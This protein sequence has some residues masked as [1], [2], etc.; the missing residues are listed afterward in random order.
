MQPITNERGQGGVLLCPVCNRPGTWREGARSFTSSFVRVR[1]S[2]LDALVHVCCLNR[3]YRDIE[4]QIAVARRRRL[5]LG[6]FPACWRFL[7]GSAQLLGMI[8]KDGPKDAARKFRQARIVGGIDK[9]KGES[10]QVVRNL[11]GGVSYISG[12]L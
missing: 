1:I 3:L 11:D 7:R 5:L 8:W 6:F 9:A 10:I 12:D 2:N 4:D